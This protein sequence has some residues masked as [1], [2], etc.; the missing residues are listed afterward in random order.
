MNYI[1]ELS[2]D[3]TDLMT[4]RIYELLATN[5]SFFLIGVN[6]LYE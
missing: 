4:T 2:M 6:A 5:C 1:S 3:D